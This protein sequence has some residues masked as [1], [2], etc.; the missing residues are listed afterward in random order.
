MYNTDAIGIRHACIF[1]YMNSRQYVQSRKYMCMNTYVYIN[2][3]HRCYW[4]TT[5]VYIYVYEFTSIHSFT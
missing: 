2:V 1:T 3:Q 5:R 4:H